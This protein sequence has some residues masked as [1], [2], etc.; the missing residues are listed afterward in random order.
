MG[1]CLACFRAK[2]EVEALSLLYSIL[3]PVD[4]VR[5]LLLEFADA[6]AH[7]LHL[8]FPYRKLRKYHMGVADFWRHIS[9]AGSL[10]E[11]VRP[12]SDTS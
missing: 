4:G 11:K 2:V 6:R 9:F 8:V 1:T 12:T 10:V 3:L 7:P 5:L